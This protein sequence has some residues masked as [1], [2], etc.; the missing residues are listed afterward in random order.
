MLNSMKDAGVDSK[1]IGYINAHATSTKVGDIAELNSVAGVFAGNKNLLMSS[2]KSAIGHLLGGA[3]AVEAI[4]T[5]LALVDQIAPPTLNL[6]N[7]IAETDID[8]VPLQAKAAKLEFAMSNSFG[9]GGTN[10][11]LVLRKI[12]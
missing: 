8:L 1:D 12:S 4:F 6:H 10:A 9:F 2:T 3:G 5:C 7:P 11:S